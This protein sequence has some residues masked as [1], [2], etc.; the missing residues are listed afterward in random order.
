[1]SIYSSDQYVSAKKDDYFQRYQFAKRIAETITKYESPDGFVIGIYG[2]WGEGKTSLLKFVETELSPNENVIVVHFNPWRFGDES[3]LITTFFETLADSLKEKLYTKKEKFFGFMKGNEPLLEGAPELLNDIAEYGKLSSSF[4]GSI[5]GV[6]SKAATLGKSKSE[7]SIETLKG[8]IESFLEKN[9]KRVL[10]VV[11]DIDR[12]DAEEVRAIF[13]LVKLTANFKYCTYL[14]A[15]DDTY[16]ANILAKSFGNDNAELGF[17]YLEKIIQVPLKLPMVTNSDMQ[18]F[19][20][21][22]LGVLIQ[23][24]GL[25]VD[26][27]DRLEG[28]I[29]E[30]LIPA[31]QTPRMVIRFINACSFSL[32][33][34]DRLV[35]SVDQILIE[36]LKIFFPA[37]FDLIKSNKEGVISVEGRK[38]I[39]SSSDF[40]KNFTDQLESICN[41]YGQS[42][43]AAKSLLIH[44]FPETTRFLGEP[45]LYRKPDLS[46]IHLHMRICSRDYFDR[47]FTYSVLKG[48][49]SDILLQEIFESISN[50]RDSNKKIIA[51]LFD[52]YGEQKALYKL[53][54]KKSMI[55][56]QLAKRLIQSFID[57]A[58]YFPRD[59]DEPRPF[60]LPEQVAKLILALSTK[61]IPD[62]RITLLQEA[63]LNSSPKEFG[64]SILGII[65]REKGSQ[66]GI[67]LIELE[68]K[69]LKEMIPLYD[70]T[71]L[72]GRLPLDSRKLLFIWNNY[73]KPELDHYVRNLLEVNPSQVIRLI[74]AFTPYLLNQG[75]GQ[76][77]FLNFGPENFAEMKRTIQLD[78]IA[79]A[80]VQQ[81]G[82]TFSNPKMHFIDEMFEVNTD[83]TLLRQFMAL[84]NESN[85]VEKS[86]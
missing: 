62:E 8:R 11:D 27:K 51:K 65:S 71:E 45:F 53:E 4:I 58:S 74:K 64:F 16:V 10:V 46:N 44:L 83:E 68:R 28:A 78:A 84:Y 21:S 41:Q 52:T 18:S 17:S 1:M 3:S 55:D 24:Y 22:K 59:I 36:G 82:P 86:K 33:L 20:M 77:K 67:D 56:D 81:F 80:L 85:K 37:L 61:V 47:Y 7:V 49:I 13:R 6:A 60:S 72:I 69:F 15:F 14:L 25:S 39:H 9:K 23:K 42:S 73:N 79:K 32:P 38:I 12:L 5:V 19:C 48:D 66:N 75:E 70:S 63:V 54:Q 30:G 29:K 34:M 57:L 43:G 35:N 50:D 26:E 31:L 40:D 76:I 2:K